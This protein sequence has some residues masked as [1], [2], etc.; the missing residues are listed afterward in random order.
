MEIHI[1][2]NDGQIRYIASEELVDILESCNITVSSRNRIS[3][4]EPVNW[5]LRKLFHAI[6]GRVSDKSR[7]A[8][9]T[10]TWPC[11]W[12][13]RLLDGSGEIYGP[14][15]DRSGAI[16]FEVDHVNQWVI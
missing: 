6:R 10:R 12:R 1:D 16:E 11:L 15:P 14:F 5:C 9:W 2:T 3:H 8:S 4:V 7:L 13:V